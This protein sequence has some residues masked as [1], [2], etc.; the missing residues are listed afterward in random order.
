MLK[1]QPI[2]APITSTLLLVPFELVQ[3]EYRV[4]AEIKVFKGVL[5]ANKAICGGFLVGFLFFYFSNHF[6]EKRNVCF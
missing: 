3:K 4:V 1:G 5:G 6:N 2:K